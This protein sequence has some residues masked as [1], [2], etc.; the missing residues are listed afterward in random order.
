VIVAPGPGGTIIASDDLEALDELEDLLSTVAGH[1]A[2]AGREYAVFYLKY[3]KAATIAEVLSA[4]FG[5]GSGG[6]DRGI[7]GDLAS[8]ALGD[9]GGGLMGDLLL[10]GSSSGSGF[11]SASVDIV[12]DAR[13]NALIVHA[14]PA[15]LDTVEQL[16]KVLDQRA[17]PEN[18]EAEAQARPI[19]VYNTTA[20]EIAQI[21][22]QVYQDRMSGPGAAMSPQDMMKMIRGGN[23]PD[24]QVQK[25]SV[26]V[27]TRNNMLIVRA[28]DSLFEEVK[29]LVSDLDQSLADSPQT[30]RVVSLKHTN[31]NAVQ[32]ALTSILNNV[33][34]N[35]TTTA[36]STTTTTTAKTE[37]SGDE[38]AEDRMRRMRRN[39][40]M[41]QEMR[42]MQDRGGEGGDRGGSDRSRFFRG[43]PGGPGGPGGFD[44]RG[45]GGDGGGDRGGRGRD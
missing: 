11:T 23:S 31:S 10:G 36:Q 29:A 4:I 13:L 3:S 16:L 43:G 38:D 41:L 45:R 5:G 28:P 24:Q 7:I 18:V 27:D 12:P 26:A 14:K 6:K 35:T 33:K 2:A 8:N 1:S 19:P 37:G 15:D 21:V 9:V 32:K 25:M 39:W 17:G 40:E 34:T 42:R 22:Q 20:A 30:T 44:F